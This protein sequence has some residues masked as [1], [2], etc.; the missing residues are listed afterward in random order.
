MTKKASGRDQ[1][2]KKPSSLVVTIHQLIDWEKGIEHFLYVLD[3]TGAA[4]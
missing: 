3:D 1:K 2:G 4:S